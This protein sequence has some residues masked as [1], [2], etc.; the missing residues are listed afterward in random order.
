MT[1]VTRLLAITGAVACGGLG[2]AA[3]GSSSVPGNAVAVVGSTPIS[4][5]TYG[6][7]LDIAARS[8][9]PKGATAYATVPDPPEYTGCIAYLRANEHAAAPLA[10]TST[11]ALKSK[12]A[13]TYAEDRKVALSFLIA[14]EWAL[15]EAKELGVN[16]S[17]KEV[18]KEFQTIK[19]KGFQSESAFKKYLEGTGY[20]VA[21]LLLKIKVEKLLP[22]KIE[23][24]VIG[25]AERAVT[26]AIIAKYYNQHLSTYHRREGRE[27]YIILSPTAAKAAAAKAAIEGG[28]SFKDLA[29][30]SI[31]H[32]SAGGGVF[33]DTERGRQEKLFEGPLFAA[34]TGVLT[35]P[36]KTSSGY[37][38]FKVTK[39]I[40]ARQESLAEAE[41]RI[42]GDVV[43]KKIESTLGSYSSK[44]EAK[45]RQRTTCAPGYVLA[46]YCKAA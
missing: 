23:K 13:K 10:N 22:P 45:W 34:Q 42:R 14:A 26:K 44:A 39:K 46:Q 12:C 18:E 11:A 41:E 28:K 29:S 9:T 6:H 27:L 24:A 5:S 31:L 19:N 30:Q 38:V 33:L 36:V 17:D 35:G 3:C 43:I 40:P 15:G 4:K 8:T 16:V 2:L 20:T 25:R 21:D 1:K 37:Y 32:T 7:W